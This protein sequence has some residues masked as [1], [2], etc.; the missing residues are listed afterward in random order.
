[1]DPSHRTS[2][3]QSLRLTQAAM[4]QIKRQPELPS[5]ALR[6]LEHWDNV[7]PPTSKPLRDEWREILH[8]GNFD[9]ALAQT[10]RGQQLRQAAPLARVIPPAVRLEIIR[11][12][13]GRNSST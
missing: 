7:A 11:S 5:V 6:T 1:V 8:S 4:A 3:L 9:R 10:D 2:D 13:K 12:C